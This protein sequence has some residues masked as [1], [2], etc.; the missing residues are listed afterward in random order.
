MHIGE[1]KLDSDMPTC[2]H[3]NSSH[4]DALSD[5]TASLF[6]R[7]KHILTRLKLLR[8]YSE[9]HLKRTGASWMKALCCWTHQPALPPAQCVSF[10]L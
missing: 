5:F 8:S 9:I 2:S 3:P 4:T 6:G 7:S 10:A 1:A